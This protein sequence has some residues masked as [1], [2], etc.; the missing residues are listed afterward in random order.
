MIWV[1]GNDG[2][3]CITFVSSF[4]KQNGIVI[5]VDS[6]HISTCARFGVC[7]CVTRQCQ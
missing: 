2:A 6:T 1:K 7:M 4:D 5:S 3:K